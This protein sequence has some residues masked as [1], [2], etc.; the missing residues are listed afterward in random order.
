MEM[1]AAW[2]AVTHYRGL[3]FFLMKKGQWRVIVE[4]VHTKKVKYVHHTDRC[5]PI[6]PQLIAKTEEVLLTVMTLS[7]F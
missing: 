4:I 7:L 3:F 5:I 2:E 6:I 1:E